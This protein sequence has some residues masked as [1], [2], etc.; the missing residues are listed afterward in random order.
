MEI[1]LPASTWAYNSSTL[2]WQRS[3]QHS[4][5]NSSLILSIYVALAKTW[6]WKHDLISAA[7]WK[8]YSRQWRWLHMYDKDVLTYML[9][10]IK[11]NCSALCN[12]THTTHYHWPLFTVADKPKRP[13]AC[14]EKIGI[15]KISHRTVHNMLKRVC[16]TYI[17]EWLQQRKNKKE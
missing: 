13:V 9:L 16:C 14:A 6:Q 1:H 17:Q 2:A 4:S 7:W 3:C 8:G 15:V 11:W 10:R 5:N 12:T